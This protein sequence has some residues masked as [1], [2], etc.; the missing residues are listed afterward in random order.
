MFSFQRKNPLS[1]FRKHYSLLSCLQITEYFYIYYFNRNIIKFL[2]KRSQRAKQKLHLYFYIR[3][4]QE[5]H[6]YQ[7]SL[8]CNSSGK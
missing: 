1:V 5:D 7:K 3:N 4:A 6:S 2:R 8:A